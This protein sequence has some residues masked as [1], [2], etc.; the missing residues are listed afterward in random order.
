MKRFL[1]FLFLAA[2][3]PA[4]LYAQLSEVMSGSAADA[5]YLTEGYVSPFMKAF[6]Y[7]MNSGWYN[8][9]APHKLGGFDLTI[10]AAVVKVPTIDQSYFVDNSKMNNVELLSGGTPQNGNVPT[11]FGSDVEPTYRSPKGTTGTTFSGPAGID[12]DMLPVPAIG[13]GVGLPK[14]FEVKLRYIPTLKL[15]NYTEDYTGGVGLFGIGVLHDIKQ[16]IPGIKALPFDLSG[17]VGYTKMNLD[18][19][20]DSS[21]PNKKGGFSCGATTIQAL[22]GKKISVLSVY[23]SVGYNLAKTE[24]GLKGNYDFN[25]D[26]DTNDTGEKDPFNITT[27]SNGFRATVGLRLRLAV[28]AFHADYTAQKYSTITGGFGINFR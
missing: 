5:K 18:L 6:G 8:S 26:G 2:V 7:G 16:W 15:E 4:A 11:F 20:F 10:T 19:G 25:E 1:L 14:G 9:A 12:F 13:L 17:F 27:N 21:D 24:L 28:I 3:S 23:G 22:I